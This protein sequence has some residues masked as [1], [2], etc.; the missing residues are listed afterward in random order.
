MW[1]KRREKPGM[2]QKFDSLWLGPYKIEEKSGSDSFYLST[3]EREEDAITSK[4]ISP[5]TL[6]SRRNLTSSGP[7][8]QV[9][10]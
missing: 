1:D 9:S 8:P 5:Q 3:N 7:R 4:W 6:F 2:H 10:R